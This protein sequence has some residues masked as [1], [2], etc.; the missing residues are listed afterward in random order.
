MS[1]H[2]TDITASIKSI[3]AIT[4]G[5]TYAELPFAY[6]ITQNA[7]IVGRKGYTV[8]P[9]GLN[10]TDSVNQYYTVNQNYEIVLNDV[11]LPSGSNDSSKR[12]A[13]ISLY[14]KMLD[15]YSAIVKQKAGHSSVMIANN[16]SIKDPEIEEN[17]DFVTSRMSFN[18]KHRFTI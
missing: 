1:T 8:I 3:V 4:L 10:E 16:M 2:I 14:D 6:N 5:S 7:K 12:T 18:I 15:I 11:F 9:Q 17:N 13:I